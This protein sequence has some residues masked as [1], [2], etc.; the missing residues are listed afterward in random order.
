MLKKK[1]SLNIGL[2]LSVSVNEP[3]KLTILDN[4]LETIMSKTCI[5]FVRIQ[6]YEQLPVN[7][8]VNI[9]GHRKGCFSDLGR[10]AYGPTTLNLDVDLCFRTIGHTIHEML[11]TLGAYHE[12]MRP[13]RD[14]Y[15]TILWKNIKKGNETASPNMQLT[16]NLNCEI[17]KF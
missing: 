15:I 1:L 8:W 7:N 5:K 9:T 6:E 4:A 12:H 16:L 10:N 13:D 14:K 3:T 11:H 17:N 2:T